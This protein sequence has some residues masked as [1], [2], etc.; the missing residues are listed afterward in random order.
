MDPKTAQS[1]LSYHKVPHLNL[2][3]LSLSPLDATC[4]KVPLKTASRI[5]ARAVT[6]SSTST[7][8]QCSQKE[9]STK[10]M[11]TNTTLTKKCLAPTDTTPTVST[12]LPK[13]NS[14]I[15]SLS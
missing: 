8:F 4:P 7:H 12:K 2:A 9:A 1:H 6:K 14:L 3:S 13:S 5:K 15:S 11:M 10:Q